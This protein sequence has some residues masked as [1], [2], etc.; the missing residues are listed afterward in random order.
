MEKVKVN[1][2]EKAASEIHIE[3]RSFSKT[4][5]GFQEKYSGKKIALVSAQ[6]CL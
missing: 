2:R 3:S 1:T 6:Q 5:G 4:A